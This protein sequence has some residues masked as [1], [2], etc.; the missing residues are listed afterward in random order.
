M[1]INAVGLNSVNW[2]WF[3]L[4]VGAEIDKF[5]EYVVVFIMTIKQYQ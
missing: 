3:F 1:L 5:L 4:H 2:N